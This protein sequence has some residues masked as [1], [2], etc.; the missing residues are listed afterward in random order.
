[1]SSRLT[2]AA[3]VQNSEWRYDPAT[4][5]LRCTLVVLRSGILE[6]QA[7]ELP[8]CPEGVSTVRVYVAPEV[9]AEAESIASLEGKSVTVGHVWQSSGVAGTEC[10]ALA[11]TPYIAVDG[12]EL[13][14]DIVVKGADAVR[15]VML[16][17]NDPE[18]LVEVSSGFDSLFV[19]EP[20]VSPDGEAYDGYFQKIRY[21]HL[22][23]LPAGHGRGG[24]LTRIINHTEGRNVMD[25]TKIKLRSGRFVRVANEDVSAVEADIQDTDAVTAAAIDPSKLEETLAAL[26]TAK[27][28]AEA[29]NSK[30]A[31]LEGQVAALRDQLNDALSPEAVE[32][33]AEQMAE[34]RD[35]AEAVMV[36]NGLPMDATMRKLRGTALQV[37]VINS[38]RTKQGKTALTDEQ[39]KTEGYVKGMF[40][41]LREAAPVRAPAGHVAAQ[42]QNSITQPQ[43]FNARTHLERLNGAKK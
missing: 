28:E 13:R 31:E 9:I 36:Q 43:A 6:Y 23:L 32:V 25:F 20:G 12:D 27:A 18:R 15:R 39:V 30:V 14:S 26:E 19:W 4:G 11:G 37:A 29:A 5:Y 42:V 38:I 41:V 10:G 16:D 21:N 24:E 1:M 34:E 8:G 17:P 3:R 40:G 35:D 22:A 33:A 7:H 2:H